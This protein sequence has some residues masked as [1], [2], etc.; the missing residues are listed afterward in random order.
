MVL[1]IVPNA[2]GTEVGLRI[3]RRHCAA[4]RA[5]VMMLENFAEPSLCSISPSHHFSIRALCST[6]DVRGRL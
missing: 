4:W 2:T 1:E 3:Y 6:S 5:K